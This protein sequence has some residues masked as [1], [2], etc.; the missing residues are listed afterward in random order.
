MSGDLSGD[1][2]SG[3]N[4]FDPN[5]DC[6]HVLSGQSEKNTFWKFLNQHYSELYKSFSKMLDVL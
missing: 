4:S 3:K 2:R 5:K 6:Q 1:L